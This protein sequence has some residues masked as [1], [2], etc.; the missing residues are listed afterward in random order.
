MKESKSDSVELIGSFISPG[1]YAL[2]N[3]PNFS[4]KNLLSSNA[5]TNA[6]VLL[7]AKKHLILITILFIAQVTNLA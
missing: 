7:K 6:L 4:Q 2:N 3:V 1:L 5:Y